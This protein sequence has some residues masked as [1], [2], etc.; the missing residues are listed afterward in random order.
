MYLVHVPV[1]LAAFKL[2]PTNAPV[3][4]AMGVSFACV[5]LASAAIGS[6]DVAMYYRLKRVVDR[7]PAP[8]RV[9]IAACFVIV[10][11]AAGLY[12]LTASK[13]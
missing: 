4:L 8:A 3:W 6:M 1:I 13:A 10:F 2:M 5:L 7:A 11:L 9:T 12:G